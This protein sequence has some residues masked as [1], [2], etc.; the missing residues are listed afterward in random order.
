MI[1][2]RGEPLKISKNLIKKKSSV[3][4]QIHIIIIIESLDIYASYY[5]ELRRRHETMS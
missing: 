1:T 4:S 2:M 5:G 3:S